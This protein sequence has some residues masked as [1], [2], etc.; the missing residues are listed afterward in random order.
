MYNSF[1]LPYLLYCLPAWGGSITS[2]SDPIIK[3]QNRIIRVLTCKTHTAEAI[4][5][6]RNDVLE[7]ENLY[8][9][10][11]TKIAYDFFNYNLPEPTNALFKLAGGEI[12]Q[13]ST[14]GN[15]RLNLV[16]QLCKTLR[17][18]NRFYNKCTLIWNDVPYPLKLSLNKTKFIEKYTILIKENNC[19]S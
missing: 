3:V 7:I 8:K 6:V 14:S 12:N 19:F 5:I 13:N 16:R 18:E 10:E 1:I 17:A 9:L 11:V 2:K 15:S 4:E